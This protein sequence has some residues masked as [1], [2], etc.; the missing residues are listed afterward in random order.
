MWYILYNVNSAILLRKVVF[1][2]FASIVV[3]T[4]IWTGTIRQV[5]K[6]EVLKVSKSGCPGHIKCHVHLWVCFTELCLVFDN[7]LLKVQLE[8]R[9]T[10]SK[11]LDC[12]PRLGDVQSKNYTKLG[13]LP[14]GPDPSYG[15]YALTCF[16]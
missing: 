13:G 16:V 5:K 8:G 14:P 10:K 3:R 15:A 7:N 2:C 9:D 4:C 6:Q 12:W 11:N 1:Y